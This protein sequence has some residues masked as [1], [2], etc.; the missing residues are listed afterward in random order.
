[1]LISKKK[2]P[3]RHQCGVLEKSIKIGRRVFTVLVEVTLVFTAL[4]GFLLFNWQLHRRTLLLK[5]SASS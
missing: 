1:M 4:T 3:V 5:K 2:G